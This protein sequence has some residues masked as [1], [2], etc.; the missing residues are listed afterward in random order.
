MKRSYFSTT[1]AAKA[2]PK[3]PRENTLSH[4]DG[5]IKKLFGK[6]GLAEATARYTFTQKWTEI[7][8]E[9]IAAVSVPEVIR[10]ETLFVRVPNSSWSQELSFHKQVILN[11]LQPHLQQGMVVSDIQ[12]RVSGSRYFDRSL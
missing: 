10:G 7:V 4:V 5:A 11:R 2:Q 6:Y 9:K 1:P 12:F 3:A 8:G